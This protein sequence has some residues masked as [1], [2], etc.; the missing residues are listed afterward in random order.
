MAAGIDQLIDLLQRVLQ[1]LP[2]DIL[3]RLARLQSL[4]Q[5]LPD[6]LDII[7]LSLHSLKS[8]LWM[9][10]I[11]LCPDFVIE[12]R[13][14]VGFVV[15]HFCDQHIQL[16]HLLIIEDLLLLVTGEP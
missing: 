14:P 3:R 11:A 13:D 7:E 6:C 8:L 2:G 15:Y 5:L 1:V 9:L 16:D 4:Q 10:W 12:K